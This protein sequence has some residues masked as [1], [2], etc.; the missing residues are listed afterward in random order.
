MRAII[1]RK[2]RKIANIIDRPHVAVTVHP[3]KEVTPKLEGSF[4]ELPS[5]RKGYVNKRK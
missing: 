4:E 3:V 1:A 2:L 5:F